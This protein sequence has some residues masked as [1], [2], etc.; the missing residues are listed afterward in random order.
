VNSLDVRCH[1]NYV[2]GVDIYRYQMHNHEGQKVTWYVCTPTG[3]SVTAKS[4]M[5]LLHGSGASSVIARTR[6]GTIIPFLFDK[7]STIME[8][9]NVVLVEKQGMRLGEH[10]DD[11]VVGPSREFLEHYTVSQRIDDTSSVLGWMKAAGISDG[12]RIVLVGSSEGSEVAAGA[13]ARDSNVTHLALFGAV[14]GIPLFDAF[15]LPLRRALRAGQIT[16][17]AFEKSYER[18]REVFRDINTHPNAANLF[19]DNMTYR[20]WA[21]S[22]EHSL[23]CSLTKV[24]VP[25]YLAIASEDEC[26]LPES[27]DILV[28]ELDRRG[29]TNLYVHQY[30]GLDHGF[31]K[32]D[33]NGRCCLALEVWRDLLDWIAKY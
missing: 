5:V 11:W 22:A 29:K 20:Y 8:K 14:I 23:L 18:Y 2:P 28:A 4:V 15:L 25:T 7:A 31:S 12:T 24:E 30:F 27:S 9:W 6:E 33:D 13:A 19:L 1:A 16:S 10:H 32:R 26:T 17:K 21:S 3:S